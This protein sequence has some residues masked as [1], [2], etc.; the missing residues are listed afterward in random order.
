[1]KNY[2]YFDL[3]TKKTSKDFQDGWG[4]SIP[5]F[6]GSGTTLSESNIFWMEMGVAATF[7]NH[8]LR[9]WDSPVELL[10]YLVSDAVD[11]IVTFNGE[12]FDFN[13]LLAA[14]EPPQVS[15]AGYAFSDGYKQFYSIL[16]GKSIDLLAIINST[17]GHRVSLGNILQAMF[18]KGK[19]ADGAMW[20]P[21]WNSQDPAQRMLAVNYLM[22]DVVQLRKVHGVAAELGQLAY[23]DKFNQLQVFNIK[24]DPIVLDRNPG[25]IDRPY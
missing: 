21:M 19:V 1:M 5:H 14:I 8:A 9:F 4:H 23:M 3:E 13:V 11:H 2:L 15:Q 22:D 6:D 7:D 24:V 18:D 20:W 16:K 25:D 10:E 12:G 17:L